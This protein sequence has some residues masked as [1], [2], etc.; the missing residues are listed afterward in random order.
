MLTNLSNRIKL[1]LSLDLHY[2]NFETNVGYLYILYFATF[3]DLKRKSLIG[4]KLSENFIFEEKP[5]VCV[6]C[7]C[8]LKFL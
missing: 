8:S 5:R 1:V 4:L 7:F 3:F 6:I 2:M